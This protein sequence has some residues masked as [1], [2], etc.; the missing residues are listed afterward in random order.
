M[1]CRSIRAKA[2]AS[3]GPPSNGCRGTLG[4]DNPQLNEFLSIIASLENLPPSTTVD[5]SSIAERQREKEVARGRL[6]RLVAEAPVILAAIEAAVVSFNGEPGRPER[7]DQLHDLLESQAYRLSHW[8]TASH[9]IN[10]RR[11]FDIN[12]L[13]GLRVEDPEVFEETHRLIGRADRGRRGAGACASITRTGCSIRAVLFDASGSR[14]AG[15]GHRAGVGAHRAA[16]SADVCGGRKD[17]V[18]REALPHR[19]AVHGTT[20]YN[21]LNDLNGIYHRHAARRAPCAAPT[22]SSPAA[23]IRST[24]CCIAASG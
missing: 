2:P 21:Y 15:V 3:T 5:P 13:A 20:G 6:A 24:T 12:T 11:F 10:Y 16:G 4:A 9:E 22:R 18:G 17:S 19:W 8:R 14:R 1:S 23:P 7:F